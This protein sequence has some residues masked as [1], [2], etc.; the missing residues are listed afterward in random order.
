VGLGRIHSPNL[1]GIM[2]L[3]YHCTIRPGL[4]G[5]LRSKPAG[6]IPCGRS[7]GSPQFNFGRADR[8]GRT[9]L[10]KLTK[11]RQARY[12]AV[13]DRIT[14]VVGLLFVA[15][16]F[17]KHL[18]HI[19]QYQKSP[20]EWQSICKSLGMNMPVFRKRLCY[21]GKVFPL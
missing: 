21:I 1:A 5:S 9:K 19:H 7:H 12:R 6:T 10:L 18:R 16:W 8:G 3:G 4:A 20:K 2:V 17:L 11:S 14:V 15:L 13:L